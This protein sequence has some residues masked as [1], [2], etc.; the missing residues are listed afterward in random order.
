MNEKK[1][2]KDLTLK[3]LK[4]SS[5]KSNFDQI[6]S[7]LKYMFALDATVERACN[8]AGLTV[9]T[10]YEWLNKS[11]EFSREMARAQDTILN[12]ADEIVSYALTQA[13]DLSV[14]M[15]VKERRDKKRYSLRSELTGEDGQK[16]ID[17]INITIHEARHTGN[18]NLQ[19]EPRSDTEQENNP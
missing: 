10:Y 13:K 16:L 19:E 14:A 5:Y 15:W 1:E 17:S 11:E 8:Y 9:S 6:F 7:D 18:N 12:A 3:E 2:K 4:A